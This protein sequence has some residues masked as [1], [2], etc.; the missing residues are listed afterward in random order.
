[1]AEP[2]KFPWWGVV[3]IGI[4]ALGNI[5]T[6]ALWTWA[7][8]STPPHTHASY[9]IESG[10]SLLLILS[11]FVL[12]FSFCAVGVI[13]KERVGLAALIALFSLTPFPFSFLVLH[14]PANW[15][16]ITLAP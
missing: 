8:F 3:G 12:G 2:E 10:L 4:A 7:L 9:L 5:L 1:M 13:R 11:T 6:G 15:R 16:H 14:V